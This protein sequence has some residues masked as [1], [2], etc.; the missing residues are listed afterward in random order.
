MDCENMD[1]EVYY[2]CPVC[3]DGWRQIPETEEDMKT[4]DETLF[5]GEQE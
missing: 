4:S 2:Y 5:Y 1:G 3:K